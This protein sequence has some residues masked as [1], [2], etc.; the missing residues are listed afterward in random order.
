MSDTERIDRIERELARLRTPE[1]PLLQPRLLSPVVRE[2]IE[3]QT[4][5]R[6]AR[7]QAAA[8][9]AEAE[10]RQ[11]ER[12]APKLARRLAALRAID[13]EIA[14]ER[15]RSQQV[16]DQLAAKRYALDHKPLCY[17]LVRT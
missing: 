16:V 8:E 12:D 15:A 5:A 1:D 13:D 11:A 17:R 4:R 3:G 9:L 10:R 14:A 7:L 6:Q 2:C